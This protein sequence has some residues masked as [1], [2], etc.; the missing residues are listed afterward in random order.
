M[1]RIRSE[2]DIFEG[3]AGSDGPQVPDALSLEGPDHV[4]DG[5]IQDV[6]GT[7]SLPA[8]ADVTRSQQDLGADQQ[9]QAHVL[10]DPTLRD[11]VVGQTERNTVDLSGPVGHRSVKAMQMLDNN[12]VATIGYST[13]EGRASSAT[14]TLT[15]SY[16]DRVILSLRDHAHQ[17]RHAFAL[18]ERCFY[19]IWVLRD[20]TRLEEL[21]SA[22]STAGPCRLTNAQLCELC[23]IAASCAQ[24]CRDNFDPTAMETIYGTWLVTVM[25]SSHL[26]CYLSQ[27]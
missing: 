26:D 12:L 5:P 1:E 8:G 13:T 21:L 27:G 24:C 15:L 11:P 4:V 23:G 7:L 10:L 19:D 20:K 22:V 14:T 6:R 16:R 3:Q 2:E 17:I 9:L 18:E 25:L